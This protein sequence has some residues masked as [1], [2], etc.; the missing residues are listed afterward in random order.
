MQIIN[1]TINRTGLAEIHDF[2]GR[3]HKAGRDHFTLAMLSA[4]A[5]DAEF[6]LAEGNSAT[7]EIPAHNSIT[8][9]PETYTI[10][11]AGIDAEM[12]GEDD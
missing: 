4:W 6:Q 2:L 8:G 12:V 10:S 3:T 7:I 1:H 9:R 5:Q 11:S